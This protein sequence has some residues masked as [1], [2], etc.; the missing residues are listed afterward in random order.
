MSQL[1]ARAVA[2]VDGASRGNPGP[3]SIGIVFLGPD[4]QPVKTIGRRIGKATNNIAEYLALVAA[5]QEALIGRVEELDVYTDSELLA[6]Q[7]NGVYKVK[8][9]TLRLFHL[10]AAHLK[11]GFRRVSVTH[12]P[13]EKNTLADREANRALDDEVLF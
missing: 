3:A 4:G 5:M 12:V 1:P 9:D 10:L 6:R 8:D 11:T 7:F 13:R 2:H